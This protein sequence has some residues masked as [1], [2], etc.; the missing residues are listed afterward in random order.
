M[1]FEVTKGHKNTNM[2]KFK[3]NFFH[4]FTFF[5]SF[6]DFYFTYLRTWRSRS[7]IRVPRVLCSHISPNVL[8]FF[9]VMDSDKISYKDRRHLWCLL[10]TYNSNWFY[11]FDNNINVVLFSNLYFPTCFDINKPSSGRFKNKGKQNYININVYH[12]ICCILSLAC[13]SVPLFSFIRR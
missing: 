2:L 13:I 3:R 9:F 5:D 6:A 12:Q 1:I 10:L 8:E 4:S 7:Y 11:S